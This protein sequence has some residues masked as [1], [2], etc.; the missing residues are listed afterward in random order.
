MSLNKCNTTPNESPLILT[1]H[2]TS[3]NLQPFNDS[4]RLAEFE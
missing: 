4:A 2:D 1:E 3:P